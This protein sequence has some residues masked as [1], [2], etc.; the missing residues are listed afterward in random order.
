MGV[1]SRGSRK[2]AGRRW[3]RGSRAAW[4]GF[5]TRGEA[6]RGS[7]H[8]SLLSVVTTTAGFSLSHSFEVARSSPNSHDRNT[9]SSS[10]P[11]RLHHHYH[12]PS[13]APPPSAPTFT[14]FPLLGPDDPDRSWAQPPSADPSCHPRHRDASHRPDAASG[15]PSPPAPALIYPPALFG[16]RPTQLSRVLRPHTPRLTQ[17]PNPDLP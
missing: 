1:L 7:R 13:L 8:P 12:H 4:G 16:P 15:M 2:K 6:T 5:G 11:H 17:S 3:D 14:M 10:S 9:D